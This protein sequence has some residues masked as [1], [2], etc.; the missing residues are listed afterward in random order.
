M[1]HAIGFEAEVKCIADMFYEFFKNNITQLVNC[2]PETYKSIEVIDQ[3]DE[4]SVGS[5]RLWKYELDG[6]FITTKEKMIAV[7]GENKSITWNFLDGDVMNFYRSFQIKL[8]SVTPTGEDSCLAKWS[9]NFEKDKGDL[10]YP[11]AFIK[12]LH[13]ISVDL[14]SKLLK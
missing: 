11:T 1:A 9:V 5:V 7:N 13:K 3:G 2:F 12:L 10:P 6:H 14:P 8:I 4:P